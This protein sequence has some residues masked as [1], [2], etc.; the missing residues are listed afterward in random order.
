LSVTL[1]QLEIFNAVVVAG[2]ISRAARRMDLSQP[3]IS[4]QLAKLEAAL[5]T[6]LMVRKGATSVELTPAGEYWYR[7]SADVLTEMAAISAQHDQRFARGRPA[8]QFGTTPPLRG[9]FLGAI[10]RLAVADG[11]FSRFD[12]FLAVNSVEIVELVH[13]HQLNCAL[14]SEASLEGHR[15]SLNVTP[16][17]DEGVAWAIPKAIPETVVQE[18]LVTGARPPPE[19]D[20]LLRYV[21][22][23]A[24]PWHEISQDWYRSHL[25]TA[26]PFFSCVSHTAAIDIVTAGLAT[27][28]GPLSLFLNLPQSTLDGLRLYEL[29]GIA[30]RMVLIMPKHLVTLAPFANFRARLQEFMTRH[31]SRETAREGVADMPG[32]AVPVR[33]TVQAQPEPTA[34]PPRFGA[35]GAFK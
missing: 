10:A 23:K 28:H 13:L 29:E 11:Q 21:E 33:G 8:L 18:A 27:C 30:R 12:F 14:V 5:G 26:D 1:K 2:S 7:R 35:N 22:V 6:P 32:A 17:F 15:G 16:L 9:R 25:P 34:A 24:S 31:Y 4:Q 20:A 19:Y 3:T